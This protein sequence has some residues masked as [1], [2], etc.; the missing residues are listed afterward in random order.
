MIFLENLR[1]QAGVPVGQALDT[2]LQAHNASVL[3]IA[4]EAGVQPN[5]NTALAGKTTQ[6]VGASARPTAC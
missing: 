6:I 5:C 4:P 1:L 2:G 3:K